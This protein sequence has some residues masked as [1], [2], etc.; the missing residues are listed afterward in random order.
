MTEENS[1]EV[2]FIR[3]V[4]NSML[5]MESDGSYR[6]V[7][8][9]S[10]EPVDSFWVAVGPEASK[11]TFTPNNYGRYR[12]TAYDAASGH[13]AGVEFYA[14]GWGRVPWSLEEPDHLQREVRSGCRSV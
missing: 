3:L 10:E 7:S 5:K 9:R 8:E 2:Q 12:I 13:K 1:I 4:Y 14:S 11:A 6:F